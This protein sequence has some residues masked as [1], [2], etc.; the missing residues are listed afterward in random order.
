[1]RGF[2][3][4]RDFAADKNPR[5]VLARVGESPYPAQRQGIPVTGNGRSAPDAGV[6]EQRDATTNE[7]AVAG[8]HSTTLINGKCE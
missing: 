3:A 1:M 8:R 5:A 7:S 6:P 4:D 2:A